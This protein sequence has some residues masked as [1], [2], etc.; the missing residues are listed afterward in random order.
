M[1]NKQELIDRLKELVELEDTE[2][3]AEAVETVK[4][5]YEALVAA[6]H[7]Q[8][9]NG[10][11]APA[12]EAGGEA[13][14][15]PIES[16]ALQDEA[17]K[18]FKQL[19]DAFNHRVNEIHRARAREE[20][21]NLAA[22]Q[23]IMDELRALIADEENISTAFKRFNELQEQW[24]GIGNVPQQAYRQLQSDFSHL[25]DQ[26]HYHIRIYQELRDHDLRRNTALKQALVSDMQTL[27]ASDNIRELERLVKEY[28]EKWHGIGPVLREEWE[29]IRDGF[30][31]AT[32]IAYD[33]INAHYR[34]RRAVHEANLQAKQAL[35]AKVAEVADLAQAGGHEWNALTER[36]LELQSA[37][38]QIGFA[39]KKENEQ[40][41]K[42]FRDTCNRFFDAKKAHFAQ[43]REQYK[44]A[45]EK[46][47]ALLDEAL[48]LRDSK[49]WRRTADRLK[50][51]QQQWKAAGSAGPR[52][53]NRLWNRFRE[54]CDHFFNARKQAYTM[55]DQ[56]QAR[57]VQEKEAVI[58]E[59]E[60]YQLTGDA[61]ADREAL[62]QF[63]KRWMESGR[64]A[65]RK[66]D[67][68][69]ERYKAAMDKLYDLLRLEGEETHRARFR[70]HIDALRSAPDMRDRL[71]RET[72]A[73]RRKIADLDTELRQIENNMGIF[74]F[75]TAAGESMRRE[76]E[77]RIERLGRERTRLQVQLREL[78]KELR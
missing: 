7:Q 4:E 14:P 29:A 40:V 64:V 61:K 69:M 68:L 3:A 46:K 35:V 2:Q 77:K 51:L 1:A 22:K 15:V 45:R 63:S 25:R 43:L 57:H 30:W 38:K 31:E 71:E 23:A 28:Q 37:W 60:A 70:D 66:Y 9:M 41:W 48:A 76:M 13:T 59:L 18:Q 21:A 54:A 44:S 49:E 27:A 39:T 10:A 6:A 58:H 55:L 20:A 33:K 34:Q 19:L 53:E 42:E 67:A 56:E 72:R 24:R 36:V 47:Q 8:S 65:P 78:L 5:A 12:D 50:E 11:D 32:R 74:S 62:R 16:A 75:R 26:F 52:D 17:D 73:V